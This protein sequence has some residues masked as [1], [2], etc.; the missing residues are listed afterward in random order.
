MLGGFDNFLDYWRVRRLVHPVAVET[1]HVIS[2]EMPSLRLQL[3]KR[4][5][6]SP[7]K[8][9]V[10]NERGVVIC[11]VFRYAGGR[12]TWRPS[13]PYTVARNL[14]VDDRVS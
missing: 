4:G 3:T 7:E 14:F 8:E 2:V 6:P 1:C 9:T 11:T 5:C 13:R 12:S 10:E